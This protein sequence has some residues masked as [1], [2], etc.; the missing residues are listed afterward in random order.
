MD[1]LV[2]CL[3]AVFFGLFVMWRVLPSLVGVR[4]SSVFVAVAVGSCGIVLLVGGCCFLA[5]LCSISFFVS[6]LSETSFLLF[7]GKGLVELVD[8]VVCVVLLVVLVVFAL[9]CFLWSL[10][11]L[12]VV[13]VVAVGV[14]A[15]AVGLWSS[16]AFSARVRAPTLYRLRPSST[17]TLRPPSK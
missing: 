1:L 11:F 13:L 6:S 15:A 2:G 14:V 12:W 16:L 5:A 7:G 10:C 8:F 9:S 4:L 17:Q 3:V